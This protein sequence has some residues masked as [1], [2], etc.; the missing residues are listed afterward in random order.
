M[1]TPIIIALISNLI[2]HFEY[3]LFGLSSAII[4]NV[5]F[6]AGEMLDKLIWFYTLLLVAV[7]FKPLG[8]YIFGK[9]G[10]IYGRS[11]AFKIGMFISTFS[12][13]IIGL[14]PSFAQIGYFAIALLIICRISLIMT[15]QIDNVT[16]Y[17]TE[18]ITK[19]N[20]NFASGLVS[21]S[22]QM[23]I[24]LASISFYIAN[25]YQLESLWR[26][27]FIISGL[28]G[29]IILG[30]RHIIVESSE[31]QN[32][33]AKSEKIEEDKSIFSIIK[34]NKINF[35]KAIII[36]GSIGGMYNFYILFFA[37]Y[38]GHMIQI[39]KIDEANLA[40]NIGTGCCAILGPLSGFLADKYNKDKQILYSLIVNLILTLICIYFVIY[41]QYLS[42]I[43]ILL[44][45]N[46][47]FFVVPIIVYMKN[48]FNI[49]VRMRLYGLS[50][51]IG[52]TIFSSSVGLIC[53][54]LAK[55]QL[56]YGIPLI[57]LLV[58]NILLIIFRPKLQ[59]K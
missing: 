33:R 31:F 51:T 25:Y 21:L 3:A 55:P 44:L 39:V 57:Y 38:V 41:G 54:L 53:S 36:H 35:L 15:G 59:A 22:L 16:I 32:H 52:S 18:S 29:L 5:F 48:L 9:I 24:F 34:D 8:S 13:L 40:I 47:Q 50:H 58:F 23:G 20:E 7:F 42:I 45:C 12:T 17:I 43:H 37:N 27:N 4:V 28:L 19:K 26:L 6:P 56:I 11:K 14:I 10:D 30:L 49:N 1:N 2:Q 46:Y